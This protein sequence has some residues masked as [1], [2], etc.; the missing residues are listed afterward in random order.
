MQK[1][2]EEKLMENRDELLSVVGT[3]ITKTQ[4]MQEA[5]GNLITLLRQNGELN[6]EVFDIMNDIADGEYDDPEEATEALIN[7]MSDEE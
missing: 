2:D 1:T 3:F 6:D 5:Q 4:E 7:A